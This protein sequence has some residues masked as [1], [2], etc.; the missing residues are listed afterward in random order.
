MA[1]KR[2]PKIS[3]EEQSR[4]FKEAAREAGVPE[5]VDLER[6]VRQIV[7]PSKKKH[8]ARKQKR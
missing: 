2:K 8:T 1:R 6:A 7:R 4:R 5:D 3:Q